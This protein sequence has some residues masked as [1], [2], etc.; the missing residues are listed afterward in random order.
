MKPFQ[1][2]KTRTMLNKFSADKIKELF[3]DLY[4]VEKKSKMGQVPI[5]MMLTL[6]VEKVL[7][8]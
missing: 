7:N 3:V 8:S 2:D 1:L 5:E 6:G 4:D